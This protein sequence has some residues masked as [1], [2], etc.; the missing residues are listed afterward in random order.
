MI[1][2]V[3]EARRHPVPTPRELPPDR[4]RR[5]ALRVRQRPG[6]PRDQHRPPAEWRA[7]LQSQRGAFHPSVDAA[8]PLRQRRVLTPERPQHFRRDPRERSPHAI[9]RQ[10]LWQSRCRVDERRPEVERLPEPLRHEA[11]HRPQHRH[12]IRQVFDRVAQRLRDP[13]PERVLERVD[14][15]IRPRD[16]LQQPAQK[17]LRQVPLIR[18]R[19]HRVL[20][21][22]HYRQEQWRHR[23]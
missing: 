11:G 3:E 20:H 2:S 17:H 21:K 4:D 19:Q 6:R 18:S 16:L 23:E 13:R 15:R 12:R 8:E 22:P 5:P 7:R 10:L 14:L 9:R 1:D